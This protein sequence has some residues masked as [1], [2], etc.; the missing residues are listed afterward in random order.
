MQRQTWQ[1]GE[2][3]LNNCT[4]NIDQGAV[5]AFTGPQS[6]PG[7]NYGACLSIPALAST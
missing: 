1:F 6:F 5:V 7:M 2:R 3:L 4:L